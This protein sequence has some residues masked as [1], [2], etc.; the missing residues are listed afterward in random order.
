MPGKVTIQFI[1]QCITQ[2][3]SGVFAAQVQVT[4][5]LGDIASIRNV[6]PVHVFSS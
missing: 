4:D 3:G 2:P 6:A 1:A 5:T